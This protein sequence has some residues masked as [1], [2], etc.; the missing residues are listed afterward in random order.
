MSALVLMLAE[1]GQ[2]VEQQSVSVD[3]PELTA[4]AKF[5]I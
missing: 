4:E 5:A 3:R 1:L 2:E